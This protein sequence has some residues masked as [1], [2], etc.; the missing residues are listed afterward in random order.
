LGAPHADPAVV[1]RA[2]SAQPPSLQPGASAAGSLGCLFGGDP[3]GG[4]GLALS[5][6]CASAAFHSHSCR[7]AAEQCVGG[8]ERSLLGGGSGGYAGGGAGEGTDAGSQPATG[9]PAPWGGSSGSGV[10]LR[11]GSGEG[12]A[13]AGG[14]PPP[15]CGWGIVASAAG[16][17]ERG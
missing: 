4:V 14:D 16:R 8:G 2:R 1:L 17:P 9:E 11:S 3:A 10:L 15:V 12:G 7:L 13:S 5:P 6:R